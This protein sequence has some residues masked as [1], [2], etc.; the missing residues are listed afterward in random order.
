MGKAVIASNEGSLPEVGGELVRYLDPWDTS[1]W[2]EAIWDWVSSPQKVRQAERAVRK[3]YR[4]RRWS[5][6][7]RSV[8]DLID[9]LPA[10][11]PL[12]GFRLAAGYDMSSM[13]GI[14]MGPGVQA[15]GMPGPLVFGPH[16]PLEAGS[17][18]VSLEG[19][20][21]ASESVLVEIASEA[22]TQQHVRKAV[23]IA[24]SLRSAPFATLRLELGRDV[25]D[26]E[27]RCLV[28]A[29]STLR[30]DTVEVRPL[31]KVAAPGDG[32]AAPLLPEISP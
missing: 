6:T 15:V 10:G 25:D 11:D 14:H 9:A 7:A 32:P 18:E 27:V 3:D 23:N 13:A 31:A 12:R 20:A 16:W 5:E 29:G 26:F 4:P 2:A 28:E 21:T 1:G 30:I 24:P 19:Q 22:G 8:A 17:Y